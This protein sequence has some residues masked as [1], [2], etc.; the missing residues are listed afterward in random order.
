MTTMEVAFNKEHT[1]LL[2]KSHQLNIP[3]GYLPQGDFN[4]PIIATNP[5]LEEIE[6]IFYVYADK[7]I[8]FKKKCCFTSVK[9][10]ESFNFSISKQ[11]GLR[12]IVITLLLNKGTKI[13]LHLPISPRLLQKIKTTSATIK[14]TVEKIISEIKMEENDFEYPSEKDLSTDNQM[15]FIKNNSGED[16]NIDLTGILHF[17]GV[18]NLEQAQRQLDYVIYNKMFLSEN[19]KGFRKWKQSLYRKIVIFLYRKLSRNPTRRT[20]FAKLYRNYI[21]NDIIANNLQAL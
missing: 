5:F 21:N 8:Q 17:K 18:L 9:P 3:I 10:M 14:E 11:G 19:A 12:N 13:W 20:Y 16:K 7:T 1:I 2:N 4:Y 6:L 15:T